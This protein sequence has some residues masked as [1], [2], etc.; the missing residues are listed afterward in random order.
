MHSKR[1]ITTRCTSLLSKVSQDAITLEDFAKRNRDA[2]N[3]MSAG[4]FDYQIRSSLVNPY[5]SEVSY[6]ITY[7]TALVGDIHRDIVARSRWKTTNGN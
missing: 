2:L 7:H 3:T 6:H 1:M 5:S 4:S